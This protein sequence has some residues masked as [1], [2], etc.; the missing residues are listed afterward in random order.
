MKKSIVCFGDSNTWG[1]I[2]GS[3]CERYAPDARWPG[4][5]ATALGDDGYRVIEE[6]QNGRMT[7][8]DDPCEPFIN[9]CGAT[10]LPVVLES[11][12]PIDL[13][14]LMLGTNDLKNH[15]NHNADAIAEGMGALVEI[16]LASDAGPVKAAPKVLVVSPVPVAE[17]KC[18]FGRLFDHAGPVSRDLADAYREIAENLGV[19]FL[20]AGAHATCPDTDCIHIDDSGH[21]ALGAAM[22]KKVIEILG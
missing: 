7:A 2:P 20:D 9:K 10:H 1:Y 22:A 4:V 15:M 17:G 5:T 19:A 16:V 3:N 18:P 21:A 11:Q 6:A 8:W 14:I 13:V 12:K